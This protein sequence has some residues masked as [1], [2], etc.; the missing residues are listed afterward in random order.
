M[1]AIIWRFRPGPGHAAAFEAAYGP[2]GDWATLFRRA[3]GYV[4]TE[5]LRGADGDYLTIDIWQS[6]S[7]WTSF[8]AAHLAAYEELDKRC[9]PLTTRETKLGTFSIVGA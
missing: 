3:P 5:L 8:Q 7:D 6:E 9:Q 1:I 2:D 4:R